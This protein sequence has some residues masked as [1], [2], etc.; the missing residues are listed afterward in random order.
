MTRDD[1]T[2]VEWRS[3]LHGAAYAALVVLLTDKADPVVFIKQTQTATRILTRELWRCEAC[4]SLVHS[5]ILSIEETDSSDALWEDDLLFA[6]TCEML[7]CLQTRGSAQESRIA[8][9]AHCREVA[10]I[11]AAKVPARQAH[12]YRM[13]LLSLARKVAEATQIQNPVKTLAVKTCRFK[14]LN[15]LELALREESCSDLQLTQS[16]S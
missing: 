4:S 15:E 7:A 8:A 14:V 3:L 12:D 16:D 10:A 1:F 2:E 9:L 11:L 13:W 6:K 5:L